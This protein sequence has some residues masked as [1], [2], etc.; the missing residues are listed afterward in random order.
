MI[1]REHPHALRMLFVLR[2]SILKKILPELLMVILLSTAILL[3]DRWL[4]L[5]LWTRA[6]IHSFPIPVMS[7]I[8]LTLS[9]F[10]A[11]RNNACY[12][13]W[14]EGRKLWGLLIIYI[15][16]LSR[17]T[18][19]LPTA[20]R[21]KVLYEALA[22]VHALSAQL[23]QRAYSTE[24]QQQL[25]H[26]LDANTY[27]TLSS[28]H[29]QGLYLLSQMQQHLVSS[30]KSA[31][32]SDI[33]YVQLNQHVIELG[34]IQA[35]CERLQN[36]PLPFAYSLL[37]HRTAYAFC[38][39]LPFA[40]GSSLGLFSPVVVGL[41]AYTFFGLNELCDELEKPFSLLPNALPL[42]AMVRVI[43]IDVL[44]ALGE[45]PLPQPLQPVDFVLT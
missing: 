41:L 23:R 18:T 39:L 6:N 35:S 38:L 5:D 24:E 7:L 4:T 36:T 3:F 27:Q 1:V 8:G 44:R 28:E 13:R 40:L 21:Q 33:C 25:Q 37:L 17:D 16:G 22:F 11:F 14:W 20:I 43:E 26:W 29:N 45:S 42:D 9:I 2:G 32:I 10:M 30:L 34:H 19:L 15:R 31:D 12:D